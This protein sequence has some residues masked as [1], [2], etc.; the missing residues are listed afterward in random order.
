MGLPRRL[1]LP[2]VT[3]RSARSVIGK[4]DLEFLTTD[5][6]Y[7]YVP[8]VQWTS[9]RIR[10]LTT[11]D[12]C[13][14]DMAYVRPGRE[15]LRVPVDV[16]TPPM[17]PAASDRPVDGTVFPPATAAA[18]SDVTG[19]EA[20]EYT[21]GQP[22]VVTMTPAVNVEGLLDV[23]E[24]EHLGENWLKVTLTPTSIAT[25]VRFCDISGINVGSYK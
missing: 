8:I 3:A 4:E 6:V 21:T 10:L 7:F 23:L 25:V 12:T 15:I 20:Y 18:T 5:P 14:L 24:A 17:P 9:Y 19:Q 16:L 1:Q 13:V 22:A 2:S 11:G